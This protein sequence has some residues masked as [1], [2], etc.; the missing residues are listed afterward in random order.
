MSP[1]CIRFF[2]TYH[3][4]ARSYSGKVCSRMSLQFLYTVRALACLI[5]GKQTRMQI[6]T[7]S[8]YRD[9]FYSVLLLVRV[10]TTT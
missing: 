4:A 10:V 7:T 2:Q 1:L 3:N 6:E 8:V 9:A 5:G